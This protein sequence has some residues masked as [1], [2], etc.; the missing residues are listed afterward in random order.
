MDSYILPSH[1][2]EKGN[3]VSLNYIKNIIVHQITPTALAQIHSFTFEK[4]GSVQIEFRTKGPSTVGNFSYKR[5][6]TKW[7]YVSN[8][9]WIRKLG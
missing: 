7:L 6:E 2:T 3:S 1:H 4:N 8:D 5:L 9:P